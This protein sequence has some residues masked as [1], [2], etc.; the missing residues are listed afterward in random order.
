MAEEPQI[1][2]RVVAFKLNPD[3]GQA[4]LDAEALRTCLSQIVE[5]IKELQAI[6]TTRMADEL[7]DR[8]KVL[9]D[10]LQIAIK[11]GCHEVE[12]EMK[13]K[14]EALD[15]KI[16]ADGNRIT[17]LEQDLNKTKKQMKAQASAANAAQ[18]AMQ[19][20]AMAMA[21]AA[22]EEGKE[23]AKKEPPKPK[24]PEPETRNA[25]P[26][27]AAGPPEGYDQAL[28]DIEENK[29]ALQNLEMNLKNDIFAI[30]RKAERIDKRLDEEVEKL[31]G[32]IKSHKDLDEHCK[33]EM[34]NQI[35]AL[36]GKTEALD[37]GKASRTEHG[38]TVEHVERLQG[39]LSRVDS[40]SQALTAQLERV[41]DKVTKLET[42]RRDLRDAT[43]KGEKNAEETR[44][45]LDEAKASLKDFG[46]RLG[47][48]EHD[49][50]QSTNVLTNRA[51]LADQRIEQNS[52][53]VEVIKTKADLNEVMLLKE[54]MSGLVQQARE[55]DT[56]LFGAKCL[57]CNRVFDDVD[58]SAGAVDNHA[59]QQ[60]TQVLNEVQRALNH[61]AGDFS[62]P[63]KML[64]VKV[65]RTGHI[66]A[67]DGS[68]PYETRE[69]GYGYPLEDV[70]LMVQ[71]GPAMQTG[72]SS[73]S[74]HATTS[75]AS[76]SDGLKGIPQVKREAPH[77]F[78]HALHELVGHTPVTSPTRAGTNRASTAGRVPDES[79]MD[80]AL[81]PWT[82][83]PLQEQ[84][85][86]SVRRFPEA[87]KMQ[88]E[89]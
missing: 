81:Q 80:P 13:E 31:D 69:T 85:P 40:T 64:S 58:R 72:Q 1:P 41:E 24:T 61:P 50:S 25:G 22:R 82:P 83:T 35:T 43:E 48:C 16:N 17:D 28:R 63:I 30:Q 29:F 42:L 74:R 84:S 59:E 44:S 6:T 71:T 10:D 7:S 11:E 19:Q 75:Q 77:D 36:Q 9:K 68:G 70:S 4:L 78:K 32:V 20:Q 76:R 37:N 27:V 8:V 46:G 3:S 2:D 21:Q 79:H 86:R 12:R 15:D 62:K 66:H 5:Y 39:G 33:V 52:R 53:A 67:G 26:P 51:N 54:A 88:A 57:S 49:V 55:K 56:V 65:G 73:R 38:E 14:M 18:Q 47:T 60:R 45:R 34:G 89:S 87:K 23:E